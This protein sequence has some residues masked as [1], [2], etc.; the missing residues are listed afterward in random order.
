MR[1]RRNV[2]RGEVKEVIQEEI[3]MKEEEPL[4]ILHNVSISGSVQE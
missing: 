3:M 2:K 4:L 1:M